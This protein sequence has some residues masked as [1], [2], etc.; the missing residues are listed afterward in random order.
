M[1]SLLLWDV[2]QHWLVVSDVLGQPICP[3]TLLT[4]NQCCATSQ[5]WRPHKKWSWI[6]LSWTDSSQRDR[7][8]N[9]NNRRHTHVT[10]CPSIQYNKPLNTTWQDIS[11]YKTEQYYSYVT[12]PF[13]PPLMI[14]CTR[15]LFCIIFAA[16][17]AY[18]QW[19]LVDMQ[20]SV[21]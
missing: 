15:I 13:E 5:K 6:N 17:W 2:T 14:L 11:L 10:V 8:N 4:T 3:K 12:F 20:V 18:I 19:M 21:H 1:S 7:K 9:I 16:S